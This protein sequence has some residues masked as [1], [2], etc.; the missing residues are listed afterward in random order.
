MSM[1]QTVER[2][3]LRARG[4]NAVDHI[5]RRRR[6]FL[7]LGGVSLIGLAA[8]GHRSAFALDKTAGANDF[9]A[10]VA[11]FWFDETLRIVRETV[12]TPPGAARALGYVSVAVY[13]AARGMTGLRSLSGQLNGLRDV[14][15]APAGVERHAPSVIAAAVIELLPTLFPVR[16]PVTI[17]I[18]EVHATRFSRRYEQDIPAEQHRSSRDLGG[19][20]GRAIGEWSKGD[21]AL[22]QDLSFPKVGGAGDPPLPREN[23]SPPGSNTRRQCFHV[24]A[25]T[26]HS[27]YPRRRWSIQDRRR[28]FPRIRTRNSTGRRGESTMRSKR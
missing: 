13:E 3:D 10:E 9:D 25:A 4:S 18:G 22:T 20:I 21:G 5:N 26:V 14:P 24:G 28:L 16:D 7:A 1:Q 15:S 23:G 27:S 8:S 6:R 12:S 19:A 11:C 17:R 2:R